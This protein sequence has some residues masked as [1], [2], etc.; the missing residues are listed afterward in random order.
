MTVEVGEKGYVW[1]SVGKVHYRTYGRSGLAICLFHQTPLSSRLFQYC[2]PILGQ[3]CRAVAFDTP[4]YGAS[5][6][7][8]ERPSL[9]QYASWLREAV[10]GLGIQEFVAVGYYTGAAVAVE[11]AVQA[12][13]HAR[14]LVLSGTPLLSRSD[15]NNA[16]KGMDVGAAEISGDHVARLWRGIRGYLK[17]A[18]DGPQANAI[19][20][21]TFAVFERH[22]W[23]FE[24]VRDYDLA[25][26]LSLVRCPTL[27]LSAS[28]DT[29]EGADKKASQLVPTSRCQSVVGVRPNFPWTAPEVYA[30]AIV[31]FVEEIERSSAARG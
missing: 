16:A 31:D 7:P 4:G 17:D 25:A 2:L 3:T 8:H 22:R 27:F 12:K 30:E 14:G 11:V 5:D 20:A 28:G 6:V 21:D 19:A 18:G 23:G 9:S 13:D 26:A 1:T 29:L 10:S 15:L 24:A